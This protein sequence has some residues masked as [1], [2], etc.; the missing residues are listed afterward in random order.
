MSK[1]Q[2]LS[3]DLKEHIIDFNKSGK[4]LGAISKQL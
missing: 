4:S 2:K 3:I 1:P